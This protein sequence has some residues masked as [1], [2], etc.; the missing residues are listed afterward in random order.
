MSLSNP[1][2]SVRQP[3]CD[4]KGHMKN[5]SI[6]LFAVT[7]MVVRPVMAQRDSIALSPRVDRRV[8]LLSIVFRLAGNPEY[9][10]N[11]FSKYGSEIDAYFRSAR[12]HPVIALAKRLASERGVGFDAVMAMAVHLSQ[13]PD[14]TPVV[15]FSDDIPD[16][17]WGQ[18]NAQQFVSLLE[19]FYKSAKAEK[20]FE[21]H[22]TMYRQAQERLTRATR[23]VDLKWYRKFFGG[24]PE[25][26]FNLL[27]GVNNG[28]GNY[29]PRVV[30][31]DGREEL[32]SI[33]GV[34]GVD[35][36]GSPAFDASVLP[37]I[38][39]EFCHSFVNPAI[40]R[41]FPRFEDEAAVVF[42]PLAEEM[43]RMAYGD[44]RTMVVESLVR[45]SVIRYMLAH[46]SGNVNLQK[47]IVHEQALGFVFMDELNGLMEKYEK[48]RES[49]PTFE[50]FVPFV[51]EYFT[52]L[53]QRIGTVIASFDAKC[54]HVTSIA[55]FDNGAKDVDPSVT[56]IIVHCD[57]PLNP[58]AGY[59][60]GYGDGGRDHYPVAGKP[61][62]EENGRTIRVP[63]KLKPEWDFSLVLTPLAF[64][65]AD[66]YPLKN[67]PIGF[68]TKK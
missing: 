26:N 58:S 55:P 49:S 50:L 42:G 56:E 65:S 21:A 16:P 11:T 47:L 23:A 24:Q 1:D 31:P 5:I 63:V 12:E 15:A 27:I 57:K 51:A 54:V 62:F 30:S 6:L 8:E 64:A 9:N 36:T 25:E 52:D 41:H 3:F 68:T 66:G 10:M 20:F 67:Y 32:Y 13:P 19:D 46:D 53:A 43:K 44:P 14:L 7:L 48:N 38:I 37:T 17:R 61:L 33:I 2:R 4:S 60:I 35:S 59:S 22:E 39:H 18:G 34:P 28:G 45:A 40:D 29:G